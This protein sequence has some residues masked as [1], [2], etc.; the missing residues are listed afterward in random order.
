MSS[1]PV[2]HNHTLFTDHDIFLFKQGRHF[3]LYNKLGSRLME[4]EGIKGAYFA[5]WAPNAESV[6]VMGEFN[7]W[8]RYSHPLAVRWDSSGIWEGFIAGIEQ[9]QLYKYLVRSKLGGKEFERGDPFAFHC[10]TPPRT[11]SIVWDTHFDWNEEDWKKEREKKNSLSA[12][13]SIYEMHF[14]SWRREIEQ[15]RPLTYLEMA[16]ILPKY[17]QEMGYTHVELMPLMEHPF[18]GSWGYQLTGYFAPT[19]RFGNPQDFMALI[20]ALHQHKIGVY[21]DWVPSHFP[22]DQHGLAFFD[23]SYLYEHQDPRQG[24]HPEWRSYIFN[25]SRH[26]VR[27]FLISSAAFWIEKYHVDGLRVDGV[28]SM[29]YLDYAR[30]QGEWIPNIH[31]GRENL[32][33]VYFL[34]ELNEYL[35]KKFPYIQM[36]AEESTAWPMVT[37]PISEGGLGFGMKWCMG[38]MHDTLKYFGKD[39]IYRKYHHNELLFSMLYFYNENFI[40]ALSHDEVVY[41]KRSLLS[42]MP[43]DDWQKFA[44]LRLLFSYMMTHPGK[45][46]LFMGSEFAQW[47]EW[48]HDVSLDW[49]ILE[50]PP[51]FGM[52]RLVKDLNHLYQTEPALHKLDFERDGFEWLALDDAESSVIAYLRKGGNEDSPIAIVCNF[53]PV[54]RNSYFIPVPMKGNWKEIFNSDSTLYWGSGIGNLGEKQTESRDIKN[55][56]PNYLNVTLP[57]LAVVIF[58]FIPS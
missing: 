47:N 36:I 27:S 52:Q 28:S 51:H 4:F 23:G 48:N 56:G 32:E 1:E 25:F 33:S 6:F 24:F 43:G 44:N 19:S 45:K 49:H 10:E 20:Q 55:E 30:N 14:G 31:G 57:P 39:P 7:G 40:L 11:A 54:V 26:E 58:K 35:Y 13:I 29:L 22:S 53:T 15:S 34:R 38:W 21:L 16:E 18:Y 37:R 12:P 2:L 9:G 5:V 42:K 8:N 50:Y 17:L 3:Q 41:G 46:L